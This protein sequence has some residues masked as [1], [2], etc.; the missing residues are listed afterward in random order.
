MISRIASQKSGID[1]PRKAQQDTTCVRDGVLA[2][3]RDDAG[4]DGDNDGNDKGQQ[5]QRQGT[6]E[7]L[8]ESWCDT[9]VA[10]ID[11]LAQ[12]AL[13]HVAEPFDVLDENRLVEAQLAIRLGASGPPASASIAAM[14]SPGTSRSMKKTS[15][16]TANMTRIAPISRRRIY[17]AMGGG[18]VPAGPPVLCQL[19]KR[20]AI[21]VV[22]TGN[23]TSS[24]S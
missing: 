17:A 23:A 21:K 3:G 2:R 19:G 13:Q 10:A 11:R 4:R 24:G 12:I 22:Q 6:R 7:R 18:R 8:A 14:G 1:K 5:G 15:V 9:A 20:D 16:A